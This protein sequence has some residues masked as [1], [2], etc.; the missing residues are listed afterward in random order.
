MR[1]LG[2][3]A[4]RIWR[5]ERGAVNAAEIV[6]I[7]TI[8][9][10]GMFVGIKSFRDA[11]ITEFAD[12]AQALANLDQSFSFSLGLPSGTSS[13]FVDGPDFCDGTTDQDLGTSGSK[14]V[15]VCVISNGTEG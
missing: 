12:M 7:M 14:C 6:L 10:I 8:L 15:N 2:A 9:C 11:A 1:R 3:L 4:G 13:S 5:D